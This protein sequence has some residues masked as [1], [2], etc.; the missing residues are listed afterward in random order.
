[1]WFILPKQCWHLICYDNVEFYFVN[2][3][4]TLERTYWCTLLFYQ[5]LEKNVV[6][7]ANRDNPV[8]NTSGI[9]S[10]DGTGQ[11]VLFYNKF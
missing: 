8:K 4:C 1:M 5:I 7:V 11:L 2:R 3:A 9:P 6:W 10:I